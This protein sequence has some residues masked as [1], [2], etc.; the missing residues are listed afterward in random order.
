MAQTRLSC[1]YSQAMPSLSRSRCSAYPSWPCRI[2]VS[3][4]V[5]SSIAVLVVGFG[6]RDRGCAHSGGRGNQCCSDESTKH[7]DSV[8][9]LIWEA[10]PRQT[11]R[12]PRTRSYGGMVDGEIG[13]FPMLRLVVSSRVAVPLA[14]RPRSES[15]A[16]P[17]K[18][19]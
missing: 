14:L 2:G 4:G 7:V 19:F 18:A 1:G 17:R 3:A 13:C 6:V 11:A 10:D 15:A 8:V 12:D 5:A 9:I 16:L